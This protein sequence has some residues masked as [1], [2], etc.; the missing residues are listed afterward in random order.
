M[1]CG[2]KQA[3]KQ[4]PR[5]LQE[6]AR[7]AN[8]SYSSYVT[9]SRKL[10]ILMP[11]YS[12]DATHL[13]NLCDNATDVKKNGEK[14]AA[15]ISLC[16]RLYSLLHSQNFGTIIKRILECCRILIIRYV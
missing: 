5:R 12:N 9:A 11:I 16:F 8:F 7:D 1:L 4:Y 14:L 6:T 3:I 13:M 2:I 10:C 15:R